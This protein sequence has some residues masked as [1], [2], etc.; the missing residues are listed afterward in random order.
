MK[1]LYNILGVDYS[2]DSE[3]IK[4][5]YKSLSKKHHPD[6]GGNE[7]TF[8]EISE[9]F[10]TLSDRA[11]KRDY[12][13]KFFRKRNSH[14]SKP[15]Q[16]RDKGEFDI[17]YNLTL[18]IKEIFEGKTTQ[19]HYSTYVFTGSFETCEKCQGK[20]KTQNK[21][22]FLG[23][24]VYSEDFCPK[25]GGLGKKVTFEKYDL[26]NTTVDVNIEPGFPPGQIKTFQG[27]GHENPFQNSNGDLK[28][29]V[30][31]E[32]EESWSL[33]NVD[34][35][36]YTD[37]NLLKFIKGGQILIPHFSSDII[38]NLPEKSENSSF[39]KVLKVKNMGIQ[40]R[41]FKGNLYIKVKPLIP[42]YINQEEE[43]LLKKLVECQNFT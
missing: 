39:E 2:A 34:L 7:D 16:R 20:G 3:T 14:S 9:A 26:Q 8:K 5:A 42:D 35:W 18:S 38:V 12:D 29:K 27:R 24:I 11:K 41:G 25:C 28:L 17:N 30:D 32:E 19:I 43:E 33:D 40:R 13:N 31:V 1:D 23:S 22:N 4:M 15:Y 37:V 10:Q 36:Y 6:M 21:N